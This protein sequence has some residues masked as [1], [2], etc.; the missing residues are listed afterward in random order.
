MQW[1]AMQYRA[2]DLAVALIFPGEDGGELVVV[3]DRFAIRGL[4]FLAKMST[5]RFVAFERVDAH[6]LGEFEKIGHTPGAL[7]RLIEILDRKSVV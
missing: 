2:C 1:L 3:A 6:E 7:E 4:M 5:T